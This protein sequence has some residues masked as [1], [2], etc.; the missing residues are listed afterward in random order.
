MFADIFIKKVFFFFMSGK[1]KVNHGVFYIFS[2]PNPRSIEPV[3]I[4]TLIN[5]VLYM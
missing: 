1:A 3:S 4:A 2:W 5:Y